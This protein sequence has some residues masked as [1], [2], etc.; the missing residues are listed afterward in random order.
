MVV[1]VVLVVLVVRAAAPRAV[2]ADPHDADVLA[3]RPAQ[4]RQVEG[5]DGAR[6]RRAG[7]LGWVVDAP[8][9]RE[10]VRARLVA[11]QRPDLRARVVA[12][13]DG[14]DISAHSELRGVG[15]VGWWWWWE[16]V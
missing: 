13:R 1:V 10:Q 6:A 3:A 4:G 5:D 9:L 2:P 12:E 14:E 16:G 7:P 8:Q 11:R 15:R